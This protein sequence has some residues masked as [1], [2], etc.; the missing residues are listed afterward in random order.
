MAHLPTAS[1]ETGRG[2]NTTGDNS[3]G[4]FMLGQQIVDF[5]TYY[6]AANTHWLAI[7][8][9]VVSNGLMLLAVVFAIWHRI[10]R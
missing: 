1:E 3:S 10:R 7:L 5:T 2:R 4:E 9:I 8:A 6:D